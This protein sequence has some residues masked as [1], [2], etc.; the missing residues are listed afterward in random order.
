MRILQFALIALGSA[1]LCAAQGLGSISV[2]VLDESR[3]PVEGALVTAHHAG[4]MEDMWP[5][6]CTT[7][8]D[9]T[10]AMAIQGPGR[11]AI[12][13]QK[14]Q[15]DYPSKNIFYF[16]KGFKE[17]I[18]TLA[19]ANS[20]ATVVLHVGPR[21]GVITAKVWDAV[22]GKAMVGVADLHWVSDPEIWLETGLSDIG[23]PVLVPSNIPVTLVV[24]REGYEAWRYTSADGTEKNIV[25]GPGEEL[26]LDIRLR[27]KQ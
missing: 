8:H 6:Q 3:A 7:G 4:E 1:S 13:A 24:S 27:P 22:T 12:E 14:G 18:V 23:V 16:G 9:G 5:G 10:C 19:E 17:D 26:K 20:V 25:L 21:A 2:N 15:D 11:F